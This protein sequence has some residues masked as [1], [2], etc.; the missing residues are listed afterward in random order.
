MKI[1][2]IFSDYD[3]TLAPEDVSV[4]SSSVPEEIEEPLRRLG[5]A[6]P[7]ALVTSKDY[8]FI[9]PRTAFASAWACVSGLEIVL[10]DGRAFPAKRLSGRVREGLDYVKHHD[11]LG[12]T[13]ELKHSTTGGLL[14]FSMDWRTASPPPAQ[15]IRGTTAKLTEMGLTVV[16]DPTWCFLDVFAATPNKGRAV[17]ELKR[18]LKVRGNALFMGDSTT[19]NRAFEEAD[20][21]ICVEHGQSLKNLTCGFVVPRDEM[22]GFL[23]SLADDGLSLD[24]R[25]LRR[26]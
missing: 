13:L 15:F 3:G 6:V 10:Q 5:S 7:V 25:T 11:E 19:D 12:L 20:V 1:S 16:R 26:R 22:G 14:G 9:R 23:R 24:T 18:L 2:A 17:R 21:A 4:Q 8:R